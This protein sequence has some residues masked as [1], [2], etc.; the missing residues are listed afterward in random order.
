MVVLEEISSLL[1]L[2]FFLF[3]FTKLLTHEHEQNEMK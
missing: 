1:L 2:L 3:H